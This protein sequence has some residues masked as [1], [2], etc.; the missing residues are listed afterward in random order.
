VSWLD[1]A[2][3]PVAELD[4]W[5]SMEPGADSASEPVLEDWFGASKETVETVETT[6]NDLNHSVAKTAWPD[7]HR[8]DP[9]YELGFVWGAAGASWANM[10]TSP[11]KA[12]PFD[13]RLFGTASGELSSVGAI[14]SCLLNWHTLTTDQVAS[15]AGVSVMVAE[16]TLLA[17]TKIGAI[18]H[19]TVLPSSVRK[20][21][22]HL[23]AVWAIRSWSQRERYLAALPKKTRLALD[24]ATMARAATASA[25]YHNVFAAE[26]GMRLIERVPAVKAV[27]GPHLSSYPA[28]CAGDDEKYRVADGSFV[29]ANG[30]TVAIE[31]KSASVTLVEH[32]ALR[33]ES[34]AQR[35]FTEAP[36][37]V[38][39]V[40]A[41]RDFANEREIL[42]R[43]R[44]AM[45]AAARKRVGPYQREGMARMFYVGWSDWFPSSHEVSADFSN[46]VV[47]RIVDGARVSLK[48]LGGVELPERFMAPI[49]A[50]SMIAGAI[51]VG[52]TVEVAY[53][54]SSGRPDLQAPEVCV[55]SWKAARERADRAAKKELDVSASTVFKK[56][57]GKKW[58][59]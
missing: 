37:S 2:P 24:G 26:L 44:K 32:L 28:M 15:M 45:I 59:S 9:I 57:T 43:L 23:P 48:D 36:V 31:V 51:S 49:K 14:Y 41:N 47:T 39:F 46:L 58:A 27:F 40:G 4:D 56:A 11:F 17:L 22:R 34:L 29:F 42:K 35:P 13:Y 38:L 7:R 3:E 30:A 55:P 25:A 6:Q 19:G 18:Q 20:V 54:S 12:S 33:V 5:F 8:F 50:A 10:T 53:T 1:V 16:R 21:S 52:S